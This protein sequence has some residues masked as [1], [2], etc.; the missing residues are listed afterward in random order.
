M[1]LMIIS[2]F[3]MPAIADDFS[4]RQRQ[5]ML[6]LCRLMPLF[7]RCCLRY[8]S[9]ILRH[10]SR[11]RHAFFFV[12]EATFAAAMMAMPPV[13]CRHMLDYAFHVADFAHVLR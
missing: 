13:H 12:I 7:A 5:L 4:R 8:F 3:A 9:L 10:A 2:L 1:L 11:C 6:L